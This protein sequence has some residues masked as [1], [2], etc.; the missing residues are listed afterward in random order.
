MPPDETD[1]WKEWSKH[2]LHELQRLADC[3]EELSTGQVQTNATLAN[4]VDRCEL[5]QQRMELEKHKVTTSAEFAAL[6]VKAGIWGVIGAAI[7]TA[8]WLLYELVGKS[9]G[10]GP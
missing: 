6:K 2:V 4:K 9:Q 10:V 7:P 3:Y 5:D 1:G 8:V